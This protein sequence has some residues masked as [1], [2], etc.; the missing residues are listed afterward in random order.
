MTPRPEIDLRL[1]KIK[2]K[3]PTLALTA[4]RNMEEN[5]NKRETL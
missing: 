4:K 2:I 3:T 5:S 1:Q